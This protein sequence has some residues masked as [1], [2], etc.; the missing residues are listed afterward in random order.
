MR[1]VY[2]G[3]VLTYLALLGQLYLFLFERF[4]FNVVWTIIMVMAIRQA[5]RVIRWARQIRMGGL[6]L[7]TK[8][9]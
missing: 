9:C 5:H 6:P 1:A 8:S 4:F 7:T 2:V 3:L